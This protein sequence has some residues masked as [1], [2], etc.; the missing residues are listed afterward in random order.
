[1]KRTRFMTVL[2][3][4]MLVIS[5]I[6]SMGVTTASAT[7]TKEIADI[8]DE[9]YSDNK[10]TY[11]VTLYWDD[12]DDELGLRPDCVVAYLTANGGEFG[13]DT[14][15]LS[16]ENHWENVKNGLPMYYQKGSRY[17]LISYEY[18]IVN[19]PDEYDLYIVQEGNWFKVTCSLKKDV[20]KGDADGDGEITT[21]DVTL[22][23]RYDAF[24]PVADYFNSIAGD[25]N[26]DQTTDILDATILQRFLAGFDCSRYDL[27]KEI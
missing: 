3:A 24:V 9:G 1:M 6:A 19:L 14:I 23:Q 15:Y 27:G 11:V 16:E 21:V 10:M 12:N 25:V 13:S 20:M 5:M 7:E 26:G 4:V 17:G 2:F 18:Q 8:G 22:I